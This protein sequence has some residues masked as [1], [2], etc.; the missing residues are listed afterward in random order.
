M[1]Q[2]Y[3]L[4]LADCQDA[5]I[6]E[7]LTLEEENERLRLER[8]VERAFY[9]AGLALQT[10]RDQKLYRSTH[11]TFQEYCQ[12][13]FNFSRSYSY[14]LINAV[15]IVDNISKNVANWQQN[16]NNILP[17]TESQVRPLKSLPSAELQSIAWSQAVEKA[18]GKVPTAKIVKEVVHQLKNKGNTHKPEPTKRFVPLKN[19]RIGQRVRICKNHPL[20]PQELGIITQI[21]NNRSAIV[22]LSNQKQRE[23]IDLKDLEI[24]RIVNSN[25]KVATP[26]EGINYVPGIG[27]EWY[28]RVDEETWKKLDQYAKTVGTVTLGSAISRLL[29][30][31]LD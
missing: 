22:E 27:V 9:Q 15:K 26:S 11:K 13:R 1:T 21:P 16:S 5:S 10:L 8:Q 31:E 17:T 4:A 19:P 6:F 30:S 23:L 25:G 28:V 7:P 24:Q 20:F 29:E 12:D 2:F 18:S 14:R 3:Q